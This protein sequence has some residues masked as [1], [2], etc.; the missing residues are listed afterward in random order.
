MKLTS[1]GPNAQS[2]RMRS[3]VTA[4]P[5]ASIVTDHPHENP[6][7]LEVQADFELGPADLK[8]RPSGRRELSC[9][10]SIDGGRHVVNSAAAPAVLV[11]ARAWSVPIIGADARPNPRERPKG[12]GPDGAA[13]CTRP[14]DYAPAIRY[15]ALGPDCRGTDHE[16]RSIE[17]PRVPRVARRVSGCVAAGGARTAGRAHAA[18]RRA[19]EPVRGRSRRSG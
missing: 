15:P 6:A 17:T 14:T 3:M 5:L 10:E 11:S 12:P 9:W 1:S 13:L 19:H 4:T 8:T 16:Y 2:F 7:S 18:D